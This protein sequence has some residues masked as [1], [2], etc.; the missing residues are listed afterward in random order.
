MPLVLVAA[1]VGAAAEAF[2]VGFAAVSAVCWAASLSGER[3][4]GGEVGS[5]LF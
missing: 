4:S 1:A 2:A 3:L 5:A